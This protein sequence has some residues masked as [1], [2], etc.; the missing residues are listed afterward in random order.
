MLTFALVSL[1]FFIAG[2]AQGLSGFGSALIAMPLLTVF[3]D[4][5][6]A[7]PLCV[8]NSLLISLYL[9]YK[10]KDHI[11][12]KNVMPLTIGSLPGIYLGVSFL[13]SVEPDLIRILLGIMIILYCVYSFF[14]TPGPRKL[15]RAWAYIAGFGTGF[16]GSAFSAGGPPAI[17]YTALTGTSKDNIKATLTGFFLIA[18]IIVVVSHAASGLT[19]AAVLKHFLF[20]AAFL[21]TGVIIGSRIY[22]RTDTQGYIRII[23]VVLM[24]LAI[25]M[26][27]SAID[28]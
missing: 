28:N 19:N 7:V 23:L 4:V 8:L 16:I 13:K 26:I 12:L 9:G 14:S 3:V 24:I 18:N 27:V 15:H 5:K 17:I 21:Q 20:S 10:L 25:M 11:K 2:F 22:D 1:I 6:T